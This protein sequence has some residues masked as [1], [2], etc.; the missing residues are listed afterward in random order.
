MATDFVVF[1][2]AKQEMALDYQHYINAE[3]RNPFFPD[4]YAYCRNDAY[5][6]WV[7]PYLGPPFE[8]NN[9]LYPEPGGA[10]AMRA[11]GVLVDEVTWPEEE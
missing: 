4:L 11:D 8:W 9:V 1:P 3:G 5:G 2:I 6:Q 7:V 10:A